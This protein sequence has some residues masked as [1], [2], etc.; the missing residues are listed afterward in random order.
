MRTAEEWQALGAQAQ[1]HLNFCIHVLLW[2][3][4]RNA[5]GSLEQPPRAASWQL[6]RV[7]H[8]LAAGFERTAFGLAF[9]LCFARS[10]QTQHEAL[11]MLLPPE[12]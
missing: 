4:G 6:Q 3:H 11:L 5:A 12:D 7:L 2:Q 9:G 8:L 1:T 10:S